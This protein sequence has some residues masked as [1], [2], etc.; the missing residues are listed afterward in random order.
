[1]QVLKLLLLL[2]FCEFNLFFVT[3]KSV[4]D[5]QKKNVTIYN[6]IKN[7]VVLSIDFNNRLDH[8]QEK[9]ENISISVSIIRVNSICTID[10]ILHTYSCPSILKIR[11]LTGQYSK[12]F[13]YYL[14]DIFYRLNICQG[15]AV[16]YVR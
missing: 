12:R 8:Q 5:Q 14:I 11:G 6:T 1:M 15:L 3:I 10:T 7:Y 16:L 4:P 2:L 13:A 9:R